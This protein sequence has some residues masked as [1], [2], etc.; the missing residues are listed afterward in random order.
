MLWPSCNYALCHEHDELLKHGHIW[1]YEHGHFIVQ[2]IKVP[3][4]LKVSYSWKG[5]L[6]FEVHSC[7]REMLFLSVEYELQN[8]VVVNFPQ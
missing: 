4:E 6:E 7:R 5:I 8:E 1:A 2:G 3:I